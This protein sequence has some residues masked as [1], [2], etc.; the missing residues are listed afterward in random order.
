[1]FK[2][3]KLRNYLLSVFLIIIVLTALITS[4]GITGLVSTHKNM[5]KLTDEIFAADLAVKTCRIEAN[6]AARNVREMALTSNADNYAAYEASI[7][8]S[9]QNI[10]EQIAIFKATYGEEDG[11]AAEYEQAF[12]LWYPIAQRAMDEI[13]NGNR[14]NAIVILE[15]ECTPALNNLVEIVKGIDAKTN[16]MKENQEAYS[17][18]ILNIFTYA[19]IILFIFVLAISVYFAIKV[20][21]NICNA[22]ETLKGG[23][24]EL[25]KGNLK[26]EIDYEAENEF[27]DLAGTLQFSIQ[28]LAKYVEAIRFGMKE[29]SEGNLALECPVKFIGDFEEIEE[30][31]T[32]FARQISIALEEVKVASTQVANGADQIAGGAQ[33]L[34]LGIADQTESVETLSATISNITE[35]IVSTSDSMKEINSLM[36]DNSNLVTKGNSKMQD[37]IKAMDNITHQSKQI[38]SIVKTIDD[39]TSQT[40]LLALNAAI[41]AARAGDAGK[42]FAVVAGEVTELAQKSS[43]AAKDIAVLIEETIKYVDDGAGKAEETAGMLNHIVDKSMEITEKVNQAAVM[44]DG[45]AD[46]MQRISEGVG[47]ITEVIQS[48]SATAQESAAASEELY[49]Q[50]EV[51]N[52]LTEQFKLRNIL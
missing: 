39:I 23:I 36:L 19:S 15:N 51:L 5:E 33:N 32:N 4:V 29:F 18:N 37:M 45:Q 20:T 1:M 25:S 7:N 6:I 22:V 40:N 11:L 2:K 21:K 43:A 12:G 50:A 14:E 17:N 44:V 13:K 42:G 49:A 48:N 52:V 26:A 9:I 38:Q 28:E 35:K 41:E 30:S 34:S 8:T 31:I 16:A 3:M 27:G 46:G 24:A 47:Q 10:N